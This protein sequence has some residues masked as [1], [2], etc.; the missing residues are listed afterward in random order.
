MRRDW[1]RLTAR[2]GNVLR[3]RSAGSISNILIHPEGIRVS[4]QAALHADPRYLGD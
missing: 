2:T 1:R 4:V 3:P